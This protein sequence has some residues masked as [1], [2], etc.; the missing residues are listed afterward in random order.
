MARAARGK[1]K[2]RI[3]PQDRAFGMALRE[4]RNTR[5]LSQEELSFECGSHRTYIGQ[6]ER[7]QKSPSLRTIFKLAKALKVLP[8]ELVRRSEA[9]LKGD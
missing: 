3:E 1:K 8:S 6:L 5:S 9:V 4:V 2:L 7:G